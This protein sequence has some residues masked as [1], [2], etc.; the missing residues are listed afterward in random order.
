V[1]PTPRLEPRFL[2]PIDSCS[3]FIWL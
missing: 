3:R 1:S 2:L